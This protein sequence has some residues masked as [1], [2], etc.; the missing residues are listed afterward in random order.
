MPGLYPRMQ[1]RYMNAL[2]TQVVC[3]NHVSWF[4]A[5]CCIQKIQRPGKVAQIRVRMF[6]RVLSSPKYFVSQKKFK[7]Y[8][9]EQIVK[10]L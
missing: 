10:E 6:R 1:S 9:G 2:K 5:L 7:D 3:A 8:F 4:A